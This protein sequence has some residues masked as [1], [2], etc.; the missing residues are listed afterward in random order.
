LERV[1]QKR[2]EEAVQKEKFNNWSKQPVNKEHIETIMKERKIR[3][4]KYQKD[5]LQKELYRI[6]RS[7]EE[8]QFHHQQ[9]AKADE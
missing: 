2:L 9:Q 8:A 5:A 3:Q 4:I 1:M 7:I 6:N